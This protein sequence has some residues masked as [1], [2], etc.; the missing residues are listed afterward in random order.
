MTR[1]AVSAIRSAFQRL[2][3]RKYFCKRIRGG[4]YVIEIRFG[5]TGWNV[6]L[7]ALIDASYLDQHAISKTWQQITG[8]SYVVD[9]RQAFS[10]RAGLRYI[11]KYMLKPPVLN[12]QESVYDR[13]LKGTRLV[14]PFGVF[15]RVEKGKSVLACPQ[16]GRTDWISEFD[17]RERRESAGWDPRSYLARRGDHGGSLGPPVV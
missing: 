1:E 10:A 16:C 17:L 12:D 11:L 14:Q 7:H 6:H 15:Y 2:L 9:I 8:D 4:L 13:V 5:E 3:H